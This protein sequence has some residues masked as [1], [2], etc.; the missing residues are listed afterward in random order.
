LDIKVSTLAGCLGEAPQAAAKARWNDFIPGRTERPNE[1]PQAAQ[2]HPKVV[3]VF[4]VRRV[5][6]AGPD[7][8]PLVELADGEEPSGPSGRQP[9]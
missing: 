6:E 9:E 3:Q 2:R 8:N 1:A 5:V 7:P 4:R